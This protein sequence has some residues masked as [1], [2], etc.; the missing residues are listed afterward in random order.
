MQRFY[1]M[2]KAVTCFIYFRRRPK[3]FVPRATRRLACRV[4]QQNSPCNQIGHYSG[5]RGGKL[6]SLRKKLSLAFCK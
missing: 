6:Q 1:G 3:G 4:G 2:R 5:E